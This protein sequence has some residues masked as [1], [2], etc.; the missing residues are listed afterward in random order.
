M[1]GMEILLLVAFGGVMLTYILGRISSSLRNTFAVVL[2]LVLVVII[3]L[4]YDKTGETIFYRGFFGI[5]MVLRINSLSW[6]FAMTISFIGCLSVIFSLDYMKVKERTSFFYAMLL[7]VNSSM[8]GIVLAGDLLTLFIFWEIMSWSTFLLISY[9]GGPAIAAG[10]KYIVMSFAGSMAMLAGIISIFTAF[11]TLQISEIAAGM[12]SASSGFKIFIVI[13]FGIA[14]GVKNAIWPFHAWLPQAHAEAPSPFSAVLS[15]VLIKMGVFGFILTMY[16][17]VGLGTYMSLGGA[18]FSVRS[19]LLVMGA[20]TILV[21]TFV[22]L[23]QDDAKKLLAWSTIAQA[24]YIMLGIAYGT[25]L[26][27]AGGVLHFLSHVVF[28]SL[29]FMTV[30]AVEFRTGGIR[31]LNSLGGLIKKMPFAFTGTLIGVCGLIGVPLTN[32]FVSKWLIYKSLIF[33][34]PLLTFVALFGTWGT[35]LY[36]YKLI[37]NIFLGQLPEKLK[38]VENTPLSMKLPM[39]ILSFTVLLFGILPGLPLRVINKIVVSLGFDSLNIS[40]WG[41]VSESGML[42]MINLFAAILAGLI[43]VW[44]FL[45]IGARTIPVKQ[46][47]NYAAGAAVPRDRYNY[48]VKFYDPLLRMISPYLRDIFDTFYMKIADLTGYLSNGIRKIY[49]GYVGNYVMYIVLFIS[50]MI[51]VQM[52]WSPW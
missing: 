32:G 21:P 52:K 8:M 6:I 42:N 24:G 47:D 12:S 10:M 44:L 5:P 43:A 20:I 16:V 37:H 30:G 35:V 4:M 25:S 26:S 2:S 14:F 40:L 38:D 45:R 9:N 46:D 18:I 15:G 49:T 48:T 27:M 39:I 17:V 50:L 41:I 11:G 19:I 7:L 36:S 23:L 29:L 51:F 28:K 3:A 1:T 31:D 13:V 34:S 22:A 33:G